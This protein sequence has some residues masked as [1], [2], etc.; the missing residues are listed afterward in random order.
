M[1]IIISKDAFFWNVLAVYNI[2]LYYIVFY[3]SVYV[4]VYKCMCVC[5]CVC[6]CVWIMQ[7]LILTLGCF[8]CMYIFN[9]VGYNSGWGNMCLYYQMLFFDEEMRGDVC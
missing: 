1:I 5:I 7:L 4:C 2:T 8:W 9:R 6:V 3:A